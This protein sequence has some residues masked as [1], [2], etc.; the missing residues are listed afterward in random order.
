MGKGVQL[1]FVWQNIPVKRA[2]VKT[3]LEGT[4][5]HGRETDKKFWVLGKQV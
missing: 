1:I 2:D 3:K 5:K 4:P